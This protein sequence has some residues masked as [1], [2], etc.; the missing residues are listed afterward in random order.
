MDITMQRFFSILTLIA[1]LSAISFSP[2]LATDPL[3]VSG[4][5][6]APPVVWEKSGQLTGIGPELVSTILTKEGIN[7]TLQPEGSWT[8]VQ[9]KAKSGDIDII[10]SAYDNTERREFLDFSI[11]YLKSPVVVLVMQGNEFPFTSWNDLKGKKGVANTGESFGAKFDDFIRKELN[12]TYTP[13]EKAF[14]MLTENTV[15]Y[16]I[17]DL[18]PAVIYSKMLQAEDKISYL[19]N[20]A[21]IQHFHV[22]L[23][24]KS[25]HLGLMPKINATITQM[26][27]K[28]L[29]KMMALDQYKNW[30]KTFQARQRLFDKSQVKAKEAQVEYDAG[31]RDR[32]LDRLAEY[33]QKDLRYLSD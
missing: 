24:K 5:P 22:T 29:I 15:D 3:V 9:Q 19:E 20:P 21:T 18:Y 28:G 6:E 2:A 25:P 32:G 23:S 16:L 27:E 30:H 17:I 31:A 11:P 8:E 33:I 1:S 4:N 7:F 13:Y 26:K 12:V 14:K 10:V